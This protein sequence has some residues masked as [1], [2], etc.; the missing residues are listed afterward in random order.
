MAELGSGGTRSVFLK[1]T[2]SLASVPVENLLVTKETKG[3]PDV[4]LGPCLVEL[5]YAAKWP[6]RPSTPLRL[7]H[8]S[9][10]QK[11]FANRHIAGGGRWFLVLQVRTEWFVFTMPFAMNVGDLCRADL[12][13]GATAYWAHKPTPEQI[14]GVLRRSL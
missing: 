4:I 10:D 13:A 1:L 7:D 11:N 3:T 6:V 8:Y 2:Y 5:K 9:Q 12:I 14:C